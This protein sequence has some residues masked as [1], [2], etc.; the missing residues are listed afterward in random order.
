MTIKNEF[1]ILESLLSFKLQSVFFLVYFLN[2]IDINISK[3]T[4]SDLSII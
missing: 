2:I 1:Q 4:A 3:S